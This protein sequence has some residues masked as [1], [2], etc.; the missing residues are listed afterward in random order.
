MSGNSY[1]FTGLACW[2]IPGWGVYTLGVAA[3]DA[4]GNV[5]AVASSDQQTQQCTT[6]TTPPSTPTGLATSAVSQSSV[7]LSWTASTDN[8]GVTGYRTFRDGTQVGTPAGTPY[9]FS[10]LACGTSYTLGAAAVDA[11]GNVS[12]TATVSATTSACADTTP[13]STPSGLVTS[14]VGQTSVTLSWTAS[15]DNVGVAAY[16]VSRNAA[17]VTTTV[18]T[19]Y[20]YSG[21]LCGMTYSLG[22]A[23]FDAAGN[24]SG[25]A[26][27]SA[28]TS[29]CAGD[30]TPPSTPTGL[31]ASAAPSSITLN[32]TPST[33]NVSVAGYRLYQDGVQVATVSGNSYT[34]TGLACWT[35][36]GWGV[37][38]LGV[39]A[40]DA[41]GNV[42]AVASS[43][44]QTQQCTDTTAPSTP[45]GLATSAVG[46]T[47]I[48]VTWTASTDNVFVSGYGAYRGGSA[49]GSSATAS[50]AFTGL[51]CGTTYTLAIDAYDA[52]GNRS[53]QVTLSATTSVCSGGTGTSW[54]VDPTASGANSGASWAN[55]WTS[56]AA[57][58]WSS[59]HAGDTLYLS[60]GTSSQTYTGTLTV[61]ASGTAGAP[62]TVAA[63]T[64]PGHNGNVVFDYSGLG[65]SASAT[66]ITINGNYVTLYGAVGVASHL[67]INNLFNTSSG[68]S[69]AGVVCSGR[70][71]IV[72]DHVT[73]ANDNNPIRCTSTTGITISNNIFQQVR[74]DAVIGMAGS[75]GGFDSSQIYG[76][77]IGVVCNPQ[78]T[79]PTSVCGGPDGV[80]TGS[81][82]SIH[83]NVF[84]ET[85]TNAFTAST[86]HPDMVQNQGNYAK[87]Y[88]NTITG[89]G[90]SAFDFDAFSD[91]TPHDVWY[92][93]NVIN[94]QT[95]VD[96]FPEAFRFYQSSTSVCGAVTSI[97][98]F[99]IFNNVF[100]DLQGYRAVTIGGYN[101]N[102]TASGNEIKNN[103]W[104]NSGDGG[105]AGPALYIGDS[106]GF[107]SSSWATDYN[108]YFRAGGSPHVFF[109]GTD[110]TAAAWV[111]ASEPHGKTAAPSFVSYSPNA[112]SNDFHLQA[113]DTVARNAGTSAAAYF[114]VDKDGVAR[115]QGVAWDMGPYEVAGGGATGA[116]APTA[117]PTIAGS[118]QVAQTLSASQGSWSN[119]PTAY[120]YQWL[121]CDTGG[122]SCGSIGGATS[123]NYTAASADQGVT[124]A[125]QVTAS[126][127]TGASAATSAATPVV[128]AA[129][130]GGGAPATHVCAGRS[131]YVDYGSGSDSN[132]GT[133]Q[134]TPWKRAPGMVGFAGTYAHQVHDCFYFKGG[135]IWPNAVFP[136]VVPGGG[137]ATADTYYGPDGAWYAGA[138]WAQP[139]FDLQNTFIAGS[140]DTVWDL[141]GA[142][143]V[144]ID[145]F[146][147]AN[148]NTKGWTGGYSSCS[149]FWVQ[150]VTHETITHVYFHGWNE[151]GGDGNCVAVQANTYGAY[152]G[153]TQI[154][155]SKFIGN[156]A[157][158]MTKCINVVKN[159]E[160]AFA[161]GL[162]FPC[163]GSG[164]DGSAA[165]GELSGNLLH[166]CGYPSWPAP[167]S[168]V[169]GDVIQADKNNSGGD[170]SPGT[171]L[172]HDNLIYNTGRDSSNECESM[173]IGNPGE[174]DY[175]WN[176]VIY[177][178][179]GNGI[180]FPQDG[181][182]ATGVGM[183]IWNNTLTGGGGVGSINYSGACIGGG[184]TWTT[185][186]VQNNYC[187]SAG[188]FMHNAMGT[189]DHN[190]L[191][192]PAQASAAGYLSTSLWPYAPPNPTS[193]TVDVGISL[194][195]NCTG[196]LVGLCSD[197]TAANAR[198]T[199]ARPSGPGWDIGAYDR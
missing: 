47:S 119:S 133:A 110:Y 195:A 161:E 25:T 176:N 18:G 30:T 105:T 154:L 65:S 24:F 172:I 175:V 16:Q 136:F 56:L 150:G 99:K 40:Y 20:T 88:N 104:L 58:N 19:S 122:A 145:N 8:V 82:V 11:A 186:M 43:D 81:G 85:P 189:I 158:E 100:A 165:V 107:T 148:W 126:N 128:Q 174:T 52:A 48:T 184:G 74:G 28:T 146:E 33:D 89:V 39:A 45:T 182:Y 1:T 31:A 151:T 86:Q 178:L 9:V 196:R 166:D 147:V 67:A 177:S 118:A 124:L 127:P 103:I 32:W 114:A 87:F 66:A 193:P 123:S 152:G 59:I 120:A 22:V 197:T 44:Q 84:T 75:T 98:N 26:T 6:D 106:T 91:C 129:G 132:N 2:T 37:Y 50:Y 192:T 149:A 76:N 92:Y 169:H 5:S 121:R 95:I 134:G 112:G 155:N 160:F 194:A 183:Y 167:A 21:L 13:P 71:G 62:I 138:S 173:L 63:A 156:G 4:A 102:P 60:G 68:T 27:V 141:T 198:T 79:P 72:I 77:T 157:G 17:P 54:Y 180:G 78:S 10:G 57:I 137:D 113:G 116:P 179:Q 55:A 101:G 131:F 80:Q 83:D 153:A 90:D 42:S 41:A 12:G 142:D 168:N 130:G 188:L 93:N 187:I 125:V 69:S 163:V 94:V 34:F 3:Y 7:T 111:A 140:R 49:V 70:T 38:T 23:A 96:S 171:L 117:A 64:D 73:F 36:P 115:P 15:T 61:G 143:R 170:R 162:L 164:G 29:A 144:T 185:V 199:V 135:V 108:T 14:A 46:Q 191:Q 159:S 97:T 53:A 139:K 35:I 51:A 109:R 190:L 181:G